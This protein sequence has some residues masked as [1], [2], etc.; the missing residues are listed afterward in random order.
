MIG[1][2]L[3]QYRIV[4]RLGAGG[5]GEVYRARDLRLEREVAVKVLPEEFSRNPEAREQFE[6]EA[7]VVAALSHPNIL[8][9]YDLGEEQGVVFAVTELLEGQTLGERLAQGNLGWRQAAQ[10]AAQVA[11]GLAAAHGKGIVHR[12]LK[13]DNLFLTKEGRVKILDF[14]LARRRLRVSKEEAQRAPTEPAEPEGAAPAGTIGYMSPEQVLGLD[15]DA[16]SDLFALGC[17]LY[18]MV[19]GRRPFARQ[20]GRQALAATLEARPPELEGAPAELNN[21]VSRCL[22]KYPQDRFQTAADLAFALR[23]VEDRPRRAPWLPA[24]AAGA[25]VLI[26]GGLWW[27]LAARER[28]VD[29]IAVLPFSGGTEEMAYLGE[30]IA[31]EIINQLSQAPGLQVTA[32]STVARYQ[33]ADPVRAGRELGVRAVLGGKVAERGG[34]LVVQADLVSTRTGA[35][36]WGQHY[37]VRAEEAPA[38][39]ESIA[40]G[41]ADRLQVRLAPGKRRPEPEAYQLYLKARYYWNRRNEESLRRAIEHYRQAID[42]D[43]GYAAAHAG[44]AETQVTLA[45]HAMAA[46]AEMLPPAEAAARKSLELDAT[47]A[48]AHA[49]LAMIEW[50]WRGDRRAAEREFQRAFELNPGYANAPHWYAHYLSALGQVQ[51]AR[52]AIERALELEPVSAVFLDSSGL[53]FYRAR[54]YDRALEELQKGLELEPR[55]LRAHLDLGNAY[56]AKSM[57]E[58]AIAAYGK[59]LELGDYPE[60]L[61]SLAYAY[62]RSGN[63]AG[64]REILRELRERARRRYVS[65]YWLALV[66]AGLG[67]ERQARAEL[68]K[69]REERAVWLPWFDVEPRF[70]RLR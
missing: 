59:A 11:D 53:L 39:Q 54:Q 57:P 6:H 22:Q 49:T 14:G 65:P 5:M 58:Q 3:G 31:E 41:I 30:G 55:F 20:T 8:A 61:P 69:A 36:M 47:L 32:R 7:K 18:E 33:G 25:L 15:E 67:E 56:L 4:A 2:T 50:F 45:W 44:L 60:T 40:R 9:I 38:L 70:D 34:H 26:A 28:S 23:A 68:E 35:Q 1:Q 10:I 37:T 17:V 13:P 27:W 16:R 62:A 43:P 19:A 24:A 46:P 51:Q 48:E 29:S 63:A 42:K 21:L 12:D 66:H 64:A 52:A